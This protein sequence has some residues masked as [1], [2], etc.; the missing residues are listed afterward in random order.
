MPRLTKQSNTEKWRTIAPPAGM[1]QVERVAGPLLRELGYTLV[2]PEV[3]GA[4][5]GPAEMA[6]LHADRVVRNVFQT[7]L[8]VLSKYRLEVLKERW[9][10][11]VR[12]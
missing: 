4:R 11:R 8:G 10:A 9:R 3:A 1:R 6:W 12:T 7:K 2:N 5:V